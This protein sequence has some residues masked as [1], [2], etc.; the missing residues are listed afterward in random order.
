[1]RY[2]TFNTILS[3]TD[4]K[5][6]DYRFCRILVENGQAKT[7]VYNDEKDYVD[8]KSFNIDVV[9]KFVGEFRYGRIFIN[10]DSG[11]AGIHL[12]YKETR[13]NIRFVGGLLSRYLY[14][15]YHG[16]IPDDYQIDHKD[17]NKINDR[18][19]NLIA[20]HKDHNFLK[21]NY[22]QYWLP[23]YNIVHSTTYIESD[24]LDKALLDKVIAYVA[25]IRP[26]YHKQLNSNYYQKHSEKLKQNSRAY[27]EKNIERILERDR[28]YHRDNK[29]HRAAV[30]KKYREI[31]KRELI[32]KQREKYQ[33]NKIQI[34][35]KSKRQYEINKDQIKEKL[36]E[37]R[38]KNAVFIKHKK[39]LF[40]KLDNLIKKPWTVGIGQAVLKTLNDIFTL[41]GVTREEIVKGLDITKFKGQVI[42]SLNRLVILYSEQ[43]YRINDSL[44]S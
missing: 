28:Q 40:F 19:D 39:A 26:D 13:N 27:R 8:V 24:L 6:P 36:K 38:E 33:E 29:E 37:Y 18:K 9:G 11:R 14:Q 43:Q 32:I 44:Q 25:T 30:N 7:Q 42:N 5:Y 21:S 2:I 34:K 22:G 4:R 41:Y 16:D 23:K 12:I 31:N 1:M 15:I 10:T 20:I 3:T 17:G 35:N